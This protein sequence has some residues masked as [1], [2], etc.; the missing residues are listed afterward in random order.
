MTVKW[1]STIGQT[2]VKESFSRAVE[3]GQLGHAYLF[4]G[5]SGVGKFSLALELAMT[6]LC[7]SEEKPC[8]RCSSCLKVQSHSHADFRYLFPLVFG[9]EH[10]VSGNAQKLNDAGWELIT[11]ELHHKLKNPYAVHKVGGTI[12][13]EWI[14][15]V[16]H[17][18]QRGSSGS[19]YTVVI[20]EGID[21]FRAEAANAM[22]K[23]LE[24]PP[25]QT[26]MILLTESIHGVLPTIKSRCQIHR[27]GAIE[28]DPF[29]Q[30][31]S[32]R[33]PERADDVSRVAQLSYGSLGKAI[34]LLTDDES[35]TTPITTF[36]NT[37]FTPQEPLG[38]ALQLER[39]ADDSLEKDFALGMNVV[40]A[41]IEET[42]FAFLHRYSGGAEYIFSPIAAE[43][44]RTLSAE[45]VECIVQSAEEALL[46]LRKHTPMLM[47]FVNLALHVMEIIDE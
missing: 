3:S 19:G 18:I 43:R 14:R 1:R 39:F 27:F 21:T 28:P 38:K 25:P 17:T 4:A 32:R 11:N 40:T 7:E 15:E 33:F 42:R 26:I 24:E 45:K 41:L 22:L 31:L 23:T 16:N 13:V 20:I 35:D 37:I 10:K 34:Q 2:R 30:E 47:V 5:K 8:Y 29:V 12:P 46:S 6:L 36:F 44:L 9:K